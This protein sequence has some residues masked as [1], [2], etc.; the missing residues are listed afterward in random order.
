MASRD[1]TVAR[2]RYEDW[3]DRYGR[4]PGSLVSDK[5]FQRLLVR[6]HEWRELREGALAGQRSWRSWRAKGVI[7]RSTTSAP[8]AFSIRTTKGGLQSRRHG[9]PQRWASFLASE[10]VGPARRGQRFI[11]IGDEM[12]GTRDTFCSRNARTEA[13]TKG[14]T[15]SCSVGPGRP[16]GRSQVIERYAPGRRA[17]ARNEPDP[18]PIGSGVWMPR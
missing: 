10:V 16:A 13:F 2:L 3:K 18:E 6:S 15:R 9:S 1:L 11:E 14:R 12:A 7:R 8:P 4:K 17:Q 5:A